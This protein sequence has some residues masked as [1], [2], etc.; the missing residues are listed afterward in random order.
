MALDGLFGFL[1]SITGSTG[2]RAP[3]G[4]F[5]AIRGPSE[6]LMQTLNLAA[7]Q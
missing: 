7:C 2:I 5:G 3:L 1:S 6:D 4:V